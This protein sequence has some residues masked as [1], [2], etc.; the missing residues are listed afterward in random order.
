MT[1]NPEAAIKSL[2]RAL[3]ADNRLKD[4][5]ISD[6]LADACEVMRLHNLCEAAPAVCAAIPEL[7]FVEEVGFADVMSGEIIPLA[8]VV[9]RFKAVVAG[10]TD[11]AA[12]QLVLA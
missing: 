3:W 8:M 11:A 2:D 7:G 1:Q 4:L 6:G 12:T 5:G 9:D 10:T